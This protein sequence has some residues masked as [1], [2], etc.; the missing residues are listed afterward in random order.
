MLAL[1]IAASLVLSLT[2]AAAPVP[3][4]DEEDQPTLPVVDVK[5]HSWGVEFVGSDGIEDDIEWIVL[6]P[7]ALDVALESDPLTIDDCL[8]TAQIACGAAGIKRFYFRSNP[9][10]GETTCEFECNPGTGG[11]S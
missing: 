3:Q 11:G 9:V 10:T 6:D 2:T 1:K 4:F 5:L 8:A 7:I